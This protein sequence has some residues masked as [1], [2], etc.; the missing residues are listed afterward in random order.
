VACIAEG[1]IVHYF[2]MVVL[3]TVIARKSE[4]RLVN[5]LPYIKKIDSTGEMF[6]SIISH[7][8]ILNNFLSI[9]NFRCWEYNFT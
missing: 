9:Q 7:N 3:H 5:D 2:S 1:G 8:K 4:E 6:A